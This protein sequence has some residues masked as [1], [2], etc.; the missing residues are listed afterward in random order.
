MKVASSAS[1]AATDNGGVP[2]HWQPPQPLVCRLL[3]IASPIPTAC[4]LCLLHS[5]QCLCHSIFAGLIQQQSAAKP[6]KEFSYVSVT[7]YSKETK[8]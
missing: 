3:S 6:I 1:S 8:I 2:W 7:F 5:H 4:G